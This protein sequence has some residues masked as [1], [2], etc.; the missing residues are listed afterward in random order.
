MLTPAA[1]SGRA[2]ETSTP[3]KLKAI[4]PSI[5][6]PRQDFSAS[7]PSGTL[8]CGQTMDTSCGVRVKEQKLPCVAQ[9]GNS[10]LGSRRH[11]AKVSGKIESVSFQSAICSPFSFQYTRAQQAREG[12]E[13]RCSQADH[14]RLTRAQ[15]W[16][17]A[18]KATF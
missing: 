16:C 1:A 10:A 3:V 2:S 18:M 9:T 4:G 5:L 14:R 15:P 7:T 13:N 12:L 6:R 8:S 11:T 17:Y